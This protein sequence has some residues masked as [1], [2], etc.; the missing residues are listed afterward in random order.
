MCGHATVVEFLV[1][2]A[3]VSDE[4][5][6]GI[7]TKTYKPSDEPDPCL[8]WLPGVRYACCGHG[9]SGEGEA[10]ILFDNGVRVTLGTMCGP[11]CVRRPYGSI[12][13]LLLDDGTFGRKGCACS[14]GFRFDGRLSVEQIA[15]VYDI[16]E[17][18]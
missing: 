17:S 15:A 7:C 8:S 10:Y 16:P 2:E 6:C 9:L 14:D 13:E 12:G 4:K 3:T 18:R 5:T 1:V 11:D